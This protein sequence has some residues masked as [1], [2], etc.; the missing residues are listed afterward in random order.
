M[1]G[2]FGA[3]DVKGTGAEGG[4]VSALIV[5]VGGFCAPDGSWF[6]CTQTFHFQLSFFLLMWW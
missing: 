1:V 2:S 6:R 5:M 3:P 4:G